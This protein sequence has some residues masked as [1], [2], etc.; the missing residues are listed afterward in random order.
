MD[1]TEAII[2]LT[3]NGFTDEQ[4]EALILFIDKI[5]DENLKYLQEKEKDVVEQ[6]KEIKRTAYHPSY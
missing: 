3:C 1:Y 5:T 4:A 6:L 2:L